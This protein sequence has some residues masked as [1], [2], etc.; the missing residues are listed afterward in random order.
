MTNT[1]VLSSEL[2]QAHEAA[3][4][5]LNPEIGADWALAQKGNP[6]DASAF[7]VTLADL[8]GWTGYW[9]AVVIELEDRATA[10][11]RGRG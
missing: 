4:L 8:L 1:T 2:A 5:F 11:L 7:A 10:A 6:V 9:G 3:R